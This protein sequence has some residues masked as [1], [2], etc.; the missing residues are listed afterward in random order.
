MNEKLYQIAFSLLK[1]VGSENA[2]KLLRIFETPQHLFTCSKQ[3]LQFLTGLE[4][5]V[6][7]T[8]T[9]QFPL[10]LEKAEQELNYCKRFNITPLF[11]TEKDF[12][13][14]LLECNDS[15]ILLYKKGPA[16][17]NSQKI[18]SIVGTRQATPQGKQNCEKLVKD[19]SENIPNCLIISGLA[20]GIDIAAHQA[21]LK[22]HLPTIGVMA[23]GFHCI[24]PTPHRNTAIQMLQEGALLTEQTYLEE[25]LKA[26]FIQRNRII[27]GM[28]DAVVVVES[29]AKGGA[30]V[31]A[32][33]A[34]T[35]NK[36]VFVFPGRCN[37]PISAGCNALIKHHKAALIENAADLMEIMGWK[38]MRQNKKKNPTASLTQNIG[39]LSAEEQ[40][41]IQVLAQEN[42][43]HIDHLAQLVDIPVAD[44]LPLLLMLEFQNYVVCLPGSRYQIKTM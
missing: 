10:V 27:A 21:A 26:H 30:L 4:P 14:R 16:D 12:P 40:K 20:Y 38:K 19:L 3:E 37:D 13:R 1:G 25:G 22:Y 35:Y 42:T 31:T 28:A 11:Y 15:P 33:I 17:V 23:T 39:H 5:A 34:G 24:Y 8:L 36:D 7:H 6:I 43:L 18:V 9:Q 2:K 44:L 41:I 32:S 29:A